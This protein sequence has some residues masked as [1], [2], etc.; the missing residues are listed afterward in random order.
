MDENITKRIHISGLTPAITQQDLSSRL[1]SFGTVT[2]MEGFGLLDAVGQP[3]KFAYVTLETTKGKLARCMNLLSGVTWKGAKLRLGDAKPDFKE[4][5][6]KE[7][8]ALKRTAEASEDEPKRKRRRLHGVQGVHANDMSLITPENVATR[9]GWRVTPTGRLIRPMRM[10]PDH[11]LPDPLDVAKIE[12]ERERVREKGGKEKKR[13]RVRDPPERARRRTIDPTRWGSQHLTGIFL[14]NAAALP[15][16]Q[17]TREV[18][19]P[20]STDS[21]DDEDEADQLLVQ[22]EE[23]EEDEEE[24]ERDGE[25]SGE[26]VEMAPA[27]APP[28]PKT[29]PFPPKP[30]CTSTEPTESKSEL[31]AETS[32]SLGLLQ[33]M[34]GDE[35]DWGGAESVG[36]D[37]DEENI[38]AAAV[39]STI[40]ELDAATMDVDVPAEEP[41]A[42]PTKPAISAAVS[43][44]KKLK[45]LFAPREDEPGFSLLG[46]LDLD[47]ELDDDVPF[48]TSV[49]VAPP[50]V[51]ITRSMIA[52]PV[53]TSQMTFFD[54]S[55][56]F[57]FP[58]SQAGLRRS[59]L[60]PTHW[61]TWFY[62]TDT[63]EV[64]K[65]RWEETKGELTAGWK[66]RHREAVKSKRRRGGGG[67]AE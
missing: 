54:A 57:F 33:A 8:D 29:K 17:S 46:H 59:A 66:R 56:P 28:A 26:N 18:P 40:E 47:L 55:R 23:A 58:T 67:D 21:E 48:D 39:A 2:S 1:S 9:G 34:F 45:D 61:R 20:P 19:R 11:P 6:Q 65:T 15:F 36:S 51:A 62:R 13:V 64:I 49:P 4:R 38:R 50:T 35:D 7:L 16:P 5:I 60:D 41:E 3:R 14:E 63:P 25:T 10:R 31:A 12:R 42:L 24:D 52:Q 22:D 30:T 43:Q 53:H 37:V 32:Q 27:I 44:K